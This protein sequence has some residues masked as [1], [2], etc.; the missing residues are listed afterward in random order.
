V[1]LVCPSLAAH[2]M[3]PSADEDPRLSMTGGRLAAAY[4]SYRSSVVHCSEDIRHRHSYALYPS[5]CLA[6]SNEGVPFSKL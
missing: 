1:P 6:C 2:V 4:D 5:S 3:P